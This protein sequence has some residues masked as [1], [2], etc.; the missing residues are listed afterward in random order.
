[1]ANVLKF[2]EF[3]EPFSL[4]R[5]QYFACA[6]V[7]CSWL[8]AWFYVYALSYSHYSLYGVHVH[9]KMLMPEFA[10]QNRMKCKAAKIPFLSREEAHEKLQVSL[11]LVKA[12]FSSFAQLDNKF[13]DTNKTNSW[14]NK[15][16][17]FIFDKEIKPCSKRFPKDRMMSK[18]SKIREMKMYWDIIVVV[19][20]AKG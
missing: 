12:Q 11:F 19:V 17:N 14:F 18:I 6:S 7:F 1:M 13:Y 5:R 20:V 10:R 15:T 16:K 3:D 2:S 4:R 9:G 8:R